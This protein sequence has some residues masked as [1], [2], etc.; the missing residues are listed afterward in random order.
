MCTCSR[1]VWS[2]AG[3]RVARALAREIVCEIVCEITAHTFSSATMYGSAAMTS[4]EVHHAARTVEAVKEWLEVD[5]QV[6]RGGWVT[7]TYDLR[8]S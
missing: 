8:A 5:A 1:T 7:V 3:Q 6:G 2:N 4:S